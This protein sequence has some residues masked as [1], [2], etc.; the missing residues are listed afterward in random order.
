[1]DLKEFFKFYASFQYQV[2]YVEIYICYLLPE[3]L[4]NHKSSSIWGKQSN[5]CNCQE[6]V[7]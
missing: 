2:Y 3:N 6:Q 4:E 5:G 1:M 7:H